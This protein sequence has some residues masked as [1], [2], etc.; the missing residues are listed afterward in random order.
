MKIGGVTRPAVPE[1]TASRIACFRD[2][3]VFST[4]HC[5]ASEIG[6]HDD[7]EC[8][9]RRPILSDGRGGCAARC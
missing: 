5:R 4:E 6:S 1:V 9:V 3:R 2:R 8:L 7:Q